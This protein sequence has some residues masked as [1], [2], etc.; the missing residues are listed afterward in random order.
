[1]AQN[2]QCYM[3]LR[4]ILDLMWQKCFVSNT[5]W[6]L[7]SSSTYCNQISPVLMTS[8][9]WKCMQGIGSKNSLQAKL[10]RRKKNGSDLSLTMSFQLVFARA[11]MQF[12]NL[13]Q[14][15]TRKLHFDPDNWNSFQ[16]SKSRWLWISRWFK[17]HLSTFCWILPDFW[18]CNA[19]PGLISLLVYFPWWLISQESP[20]WH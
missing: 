10:R 17:A 18:W 15:F 20:T 5:K 1:M 19:R 3:I 11:T 14:L 13:L 8:D 4:V 6:S 12:C 7:K 16:K 9:I 2:Y